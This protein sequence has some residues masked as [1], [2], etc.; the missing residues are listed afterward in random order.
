MNVFITFYEVS[1]TFYVTNVLWSIFMFDMNVTL[2]R[3]IIQIAL[4][5][6]DQINMD[7][8]TVMENIS[9]LT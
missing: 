1:T 3:Y 4:V 7:G 9:S 2:M 6:I 5:L 8:K